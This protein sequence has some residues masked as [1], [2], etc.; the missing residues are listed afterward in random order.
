MKNSI[1]DYDKDGY[2][3]L[4]RNFDS[5]GFNFKFVK[6]LENGWKIYKKTHNKLGYVKYELILPKKQDAF[7]FHNNP[8]PAKWVYPGNSNFGR[9]GFDCISLE[10]AEKRHKELLLKK[11][12]K[13]HKED[14]KL[15]VPTKPFTIKDLQNDKNNDKWSYSQI[16]SKLKE[17]LE[18]KKIK[19]TGEKENNVGKSSKVY[20]LIK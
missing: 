11:D 9:T 13:E 8:I 1:K 7:V 18:Q 15:F 19:V 6:D 12:E 17:L 16:T 14:K 20:S 3:L 4:E 10:V 5:C 2:L